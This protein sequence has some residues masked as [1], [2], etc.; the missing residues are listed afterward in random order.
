MDEL[1]EDLRAIKQHLGL[2]G[3]KD[4]TEAKPAPAMGNDDEDSQGGFGGYGG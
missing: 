4:D 2:G 3:D 1:C